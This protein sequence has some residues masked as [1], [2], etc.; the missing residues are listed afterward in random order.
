MRARGIPEDPLRWID[1]FRSERT[2]TIV[3]NGQSSKS[4][5]LPQAELPQGLPLSPILFLFFDA[6]LVQTPI[7]KNGGAIAFVD[8]YT[9]WVSGPTAQSNSRGIQ[10][11]IDKALDWERR[12]GATFEA[13]K[14]AIIHFTR[15]TGRVDSEP[16]TIRGER[17]FPKD[18]VQ[19]IGVVMDSR[20]HCKQ[21]IARAATRVQELRWKTEA[22]QGNGSLDNEA[23]VHSHG[24]PCGGLRLQCLRAEQYWRMRSIEYKDRGTSNHRIRYKRGDRSG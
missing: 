9:T 4:R 7:G 22:T 11:V 8:D 16:F 15:Y 3:I 13:E 23:V 21:H 10:A 18:Q 19:I 1:A 5:P 2:A 12:S 20:L 14:T 17:V 6:D 24:G